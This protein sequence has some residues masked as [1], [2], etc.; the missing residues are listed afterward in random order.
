MTSLRNLLAIVLWFSSVGASALETLEHEGIYIDFPSY[1]LELAAG[2]N[3]SL[4]GMLAFLSQWGLPVQSPV[5]ILLDEWRDIPD[6]VVDVIPHKEIRI[7]IRAPGV[8]EEGYTEADPWAYFMFKGLCLQGIFGMRSGIPGVLY[9]GFGEIISPNRVLPPWLDYGICALLYERYK[10]DAVAAPLETAIF[11]TAP[12]PSLDFISHHPEIWPGDQAY[13]IYGRPFVAWIDRR[14]GW[15]KILEFLRVHGG[16]IVPWE[17]DLKAI[18]V[19]GKTGAELWN[20]FRKDQVRP[21]DVPPGLHVDGFWPDP[22]V[23]WNN[24]GVFPGKLRV[25]RRGRYGYVDSSEVLWLSEYPE[26]LNQWDYPGTSRIFR[27]SNQ[28]ETSLELY[29]LWDPGPGRVVVGR[30]GHRSSLVIFPDD[31]AGG[32]GR[33][34]PDEMDDAEIIPGPPGVIQLSGPVRNSRGAIAVAGNTGGNW[35]IWVHDGE[36]HRITDSPS[37][38]LDPWWVDDTL[39]WASNATGKFQI[40]TAEGEAITFAAH[41]ALLPRNGKYIELT[42]NG[43]QIRHYESKGSGLPR[44]GY[45]A[46]IGGATAESEMTTK[47]TAYNPFDSLWPNYIEPDVFAGIS[48][49]QLGLITDGRDVSGDYFFDAGVRYSFEDD[50][51]ALQTQFQRKTLGARYARYPLSYETALDQSVSEK[52]N[53]IALYWQPLWPDRKTEDRV[54]KSEKGSD[55]ALDEIELSLNYRIYGPLEGPGSTETEAWFAVSARKSLESLHVWGNVELFT[56]DRQSISAGA[57]FRFGDQVI[58]TLQ[59]MGGKSWGEDTNGHT[60]FRIGGDV[61]EGAFTRRPTRLFPVRGFES[62]VIEAPA[63]AAASVETHWPLANLQFGYKALPLFLHRL[64]FGAFVDAGYAKVSSRSVDYLVGA[65]FELLTSLELG[66]GSLS[67][68]RI[69]VAWPLVQPDDLDQE[70]PVLVFQLGAPL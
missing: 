62:N 69:G 70:G 53:D 18:D 6:V 34:R 10:N 35:D 56:E 15:S 31:G 54:L 28:I 26:T 1:E 16:G 43:W 66:W 13:R 20:E 23:Y 50:F 9:K 5:H 42:A 36:W 11:E 48:S 7:P 30:R 68:F 51:L 3:E 65:G 59:L 37:I 44:L 40:H 32:L 25:G 33:A 4:P 63:A 21:V 27:Y 47:T 19:F 55:Y 64:T 49:L 8:L 22:L 39:I 17:I 14:Y 24:A 12:I 46:E 52:R 29:S 41:G 67:T 61:T 38:E 60:S 45:V 58:T 57:A 2:L